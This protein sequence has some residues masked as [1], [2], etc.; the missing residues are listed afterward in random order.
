MGQFCISFYHDLIPRRKKKQNIPKDA[1]WRALQFTNDSLFY[2]CTFDYQ[3][4]QNSVRWNFNATE[5]DHNI[6]FFSY[7]VLL[8]LNMFS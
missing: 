4:E 6:P 5:N 2:S 1:A 8:S 3:N 7:F